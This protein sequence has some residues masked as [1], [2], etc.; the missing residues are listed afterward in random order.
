MSKIIGIVLALL[1]FVTIFM[2]SVASPDRAEKLFKHYKKVFWNL[3]R[4]IFDDFYDVCKE[5]NFNLTI[6]L[7]IA[8]A[9]SDFYPYACSFAGARGLMQ[10]MPFNVD[11]P[12]NLWKTKYNIRSG[13]RLLKD[14]F[15]MSNYNIVETLQYYNYG[16]NSSVGNSRYIAKIIKKIAHFEPQRTLAM[17]R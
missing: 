12:H 9:E 14:Y 13:I 2:P 16:P 10:V 1:L 15:A 11:K 6:A 8:S 5:E 7:S 4:V 3:D 17:L